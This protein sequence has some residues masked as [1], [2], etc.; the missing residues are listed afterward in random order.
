METE[1]VVF[2]IR[3]VLTCLLLC[4]L[5]VIDAQETV[6]PE[7]AAKMAKG[8]DLFKKSVRPILIGRCL[9]CHGGES[10]E[11]EL[12]M[13]THEGLMRGGAEGVVVVPGKPMQSP[14][15]RMVAHLDEP[16]MPEDGAKLSKIA[17]QQLFQWIELGAPYDRPLR[18]TTDDDPL[19]WTTR[20]IDDSRRDFWSLQP[21]INATPPALEDQW[22]QT[23]IDRFILAGLREHGLQPNETAGK[24]RLIRRA[25]FDLIGLPPSAEE[26]EQFVSDADPRA[27]ERLID[28]LLAGQHYGER[29]GRHWLDVARFAESHGFEQDYDRPHAYH[30]R[31]FV[32][33]ALNE[34]LPYDQFVRWQLAGDEFAPENPL[35]MMATGFLGA[36]VFPTQ[37]TEKEF[38]SARYDALDDSTL[39]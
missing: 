22:V 5:G 4:P 18:E 9:K 27:Y 37:L 8:L 11:S 14:L 33:R 10:V 31:D 17:L 13:T 21:L 36:G 1:P 29:W 20:K 23:P 15:Y 19:A 3:V 2:N 7:H 32:I 30:F 25:Y 6:S 12:E 28:R 35:A 34:D 38:E 39:R 16:F 24:H 26:V